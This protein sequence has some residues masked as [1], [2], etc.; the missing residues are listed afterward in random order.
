MN[1][2]L[3]TVS[4]VNDTPIQMLSYIIKGHCTDIHC[5][6]MPCFLLL[7]MCSAYV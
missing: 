7:I 5:M 4:F 2:S 6:L 1:F 3:P